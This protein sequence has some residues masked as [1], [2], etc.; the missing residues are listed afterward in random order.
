MSPSPSESAE[1]IRIV[2]L[3]AALVA[4]HEILP[5]V[6]LG[7]DPGL[8]FEPSQVGGDGYP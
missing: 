3:E 1:L 8:T 4:P 7:V 6:R 5:Q 2:G